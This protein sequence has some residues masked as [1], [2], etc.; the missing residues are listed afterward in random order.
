MSEDRMISVYYIKMYSVG[1]VASRMWF[2]QRF[3][4]THQLIQKLVGITW[5]NDGVFSPSFLP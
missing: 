3:M 2:L 5:Q 4:E 1:I